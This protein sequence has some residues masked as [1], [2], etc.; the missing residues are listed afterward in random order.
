MV[1]SVT[2]ITFEVSI[3]N[4]KIMTSK[5]KEALE[6]KLKTRTTEQLKNDARAAM[7]SV[8]ATANTIFVLAL[9]ELETRLSAED[10]TKFEESL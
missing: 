7:E 3:T 2:Y 9:A 10:Y 5:I 1:K 8:Q 6:S 4:R